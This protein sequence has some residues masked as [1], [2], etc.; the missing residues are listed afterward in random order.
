MSKSAG[1]EDKAW[2]RSHLRE[3]QQGGVEREDR[4]V[5]SVWVLCGLGFSGLDHHVEKLASVPPCWLRF[6][7]K[8]AFKRSQTT[9]KKGSFQEAGQGCDETQQ[10]W[11]MFLTFS[12]WFFLGCMME[13]VPLSSRR[14][15]VKADFPTLCATLWLTI[16]GAWQDSRQ[17]KFWQNPVTSYWHHGTW[18]VGSIELGFPTCCYTT[19]PFRCLETL[20]LVVLF[21]HQ[22]WCQQVFTVVK[23]KNFWKN[24]TVKKN[25]RHSGLSRFPTSCVQ[26]K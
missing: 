1:N 19:L 11:W 14:S 22:Q 15:T 3:T 13:K 5:V 16:I 24:I 9:H 6:S 21:F 10:S 8:T 18:Q 23:C 25:S 26:F 17:R 2:K 4:H 20:S 7:H 12:R